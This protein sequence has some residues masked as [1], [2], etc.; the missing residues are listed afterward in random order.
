MEGWSS[1]CLYSCFLPYHCV[2]TSWSRS[3]QYDGTAIQAGRQEE[4][5][6]ERKKTV[7]TDWKCGFHSCWILPLCHSSAGLLAA[8]PQRLV[9]MC[10]PERPYVYFIKVKCACVAPCCWQGIIITS[11]LF[12][13]QNDSDQ[14]R[15]KKKA[16]VGLFVCHLSWCTF[17]KLA[18]LKTIALSRE[19]L[20]LI[21]LLQVCLEHK[22]HMSTVKSFFHS[23]RTE[24]VNT[25]NLAQFRS[26]HYFS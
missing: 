10:E 6:E 8:P 11:N 4:G 20:V 16:V 23:G 17:L 9:A 25:V 13:M 12:P 15:C 26:S 18:A 21:V 2:K 1:H 22:H 5:K 24:F 3:W 7:P 14:Q 19:E